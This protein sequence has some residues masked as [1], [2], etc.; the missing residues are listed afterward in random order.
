MVKL[1]K[2]VMNKQIVLSLLVAIVVL[3][4]VINW[5]TPQDGS[6]PASAPGDATQQ[7]DYFTQS[8]YE[9]DNARS[10]SMEL[11]EENGESAELTKQTRWMQQETTIE[12]LIKAKGYE[13]AVCY[14]SESSCNVI[15]KAQGLTAGDV[16]QIRDIIISNSSVKTT[17]IKISE[18]N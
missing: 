11:L 8:K 9:R 5:V 7:L 14:L 16:A 15:V 10:K 18:H 17:G 3:A 2:I 4:G 13:N 6:Q 1:R 12:N